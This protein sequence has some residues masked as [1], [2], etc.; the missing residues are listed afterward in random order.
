MKPNIAQVI[1][2]FLEENGDRYN[3]SNSFSIKVLAIDLQE[4]IKS[5][6]LD[7]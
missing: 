5:L 6:E 3:L 2:A 1:E 7:A 4:E